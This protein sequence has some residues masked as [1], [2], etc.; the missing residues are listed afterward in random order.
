MRAKR[1]NPHHRVK[2]A[3]RR[4]PLRGKPSSGGKIYIYG[5]HALTEALQNTP[6]VI[7]KVF[8]SPDMKDKELRTLLTKH[9]ISVAELVQGKGKELVGRDTSHQGIIATMDPKN[10]LIS[11]EDFLQT[12]DVKK[13]PGI[14]VLGEALSKSYGVTGRVQQRP[15]GLTWSAD[16]APRGILVNAVA[17]GQIMTEMMDKLVADG[18]L[19]AVKDRL[20]KEPQVMLSGGMKDGP[21]EYGRLR[22]PVRYGRA[23]H[24][25]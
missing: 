10:L 19:P 13:N 5:K 8:L 7:R 17:P 9:Q 22:L 1:N 23:V 25:R 14:V 16:L 15:R 20:P 18:K 21:G 12:L 3:A 4:E 24:L 11:L 2:H 6:Q